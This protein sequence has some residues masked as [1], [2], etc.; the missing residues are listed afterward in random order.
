[1]PPMVEAPR[2]SRCEPRAAS[3]ETRR[4][5]KPPNHIESKTNE[6]R[7]PYH[8]PPTENCRQPS[9]K[10]VVHRHLSLLRSVEYPCLDSYVRVPWRH[11]TDQPPGRGPWS[12]PLQSLTRKP[13]MPKQSSPPSSP[14]SAT[15]N[16]IRR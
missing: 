12:N 13:L 4:D 1:M 8:T 14:N 16:G 6:T 3:L 11:H 7:T 5:N 10:P 15:C 2:W 9:P